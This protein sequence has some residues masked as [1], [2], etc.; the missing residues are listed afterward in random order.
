MKN[1]G[2]DRWKKIEKLMDEALEMELSER[3]AYVRKKGGDDEA[4]IADVLKMLTASQAAGTFLESKSKTH[5]QG[6]LAR[7]AAVVAEGDSETD[8]IKTVGPYRLIRQLGRGG[9]GQVFLAVRDDEA[10]KRY[11]A[12][13]II[14]RGMDTQDIL[15]RFRVERQILA[16]LTHP[17]IAHLLDGGAT[18]EGLSYFVMEYVDGVPINRYCNEN[19]LSLE[20]RLKLF[21][22]VAAA[23]HYA[24]Q[25]LIVHRD[26]KPANILVTT[27]GDVKLLD[28]GIAKFLNP[29]LVGYTLPMT[30]TEMR[31]MTPE[32]AS[33]EQIRG[34][35]VTTASD[36]YQLGI[37][38]YELLTGHCPFSFQTV[39]RG[40]IEKIILEKAPEKPSTMI[41]RVEELPRAI[42]NP[43]LISVQ[44]RTPLERLRKQLTGDLDHIVLMALRKEIDRRYQSADQLL[45]DIQNYRAGRPVTAQADTWRY[46]TS[47]FVQRN[48]M[49][50]GAT[51]LV[52]LLLII[53]T[54]LSVQFA[55]VTAEQRDQIALQAQ[56]AEQVKD[57]LIGIFEQAN[58]EFSTGEGLNARQ[59]V[60]LGAK[61][62]LPKLAD[63]PAI[64]SEIMYTIALIYSQL[65]L[66]EE[67][68]PLV[69]R[70]LE[71]ER[72]LSEDGVS[73][74]LARSLYGMGYLEDE[75]GEGTLAV[76]Y[77]SKSL[78]IRR[79]LFGESNLK[80][81][82]SL[83]E[84][85]VAM[86][87]HTNADSDTLLTLFEQALNIRLALLEDGDKDIAQTL[88]NIASVH[89]DMGNDDLAE[90]T[91]RQALAMIEDHLGVKHPFYAST[92]YNL[93]TLLKD[94][95]PYEAERLFRMALGIRINLYGTEHDA[96][97]NTLNWLGRV[98]QAQGLLSEAEGFFLESKD[99]HE[100]IFG[101]NV[102]V[103][104]R[105]WD[106]LGG[107]YEVSGRT[108][109]ALRAY[110]QA[111]SIARIAGPSYHP[112]TFTMHQNLAR[113]Q[114]SSGNYRAAS[115]NLK[116]VIDDFLEDWTD[117]DPDIAEARLSL[118]ECLVELR[119]RD[120]AIS[121]LDKALG[122]FEADAE[123]YTAAIAR[124]QKLKTR[125]GGARL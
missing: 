75:L 9:M 50:V 25:N 77:L 71:I 96:V 21:V 41:S 98:K 8:E 2:P 125:A 84:L 66:W 46:R 44:R 114:M 28:F 5:L 59:L 45:Q 104:A 37:L 122:F 63:Q 58:P 80:T 53:T 87:N 20:N 42:V 103:V 112:A 85:A 97:A 115:A 100:R 107:F 1:V 94:K 19:R 123:Y 26:L 38:L 31:L 48:K 17:N 18:D 62:V 34:N 69:E 92:L 22:K 93:G 78:Q 49:G 90:S 14:R 88:V 81:A 56:K 11:V 89:T 120:E 30:R 47:K 117:N 51:A 29:D 4:L 91:Y 55:I 43:E 110:S 23:V 86:Y 35:T 82:E 67:A 105:D 6:E 68:K 72:E 24:H 108:E 73:D 57:F 111:V 76:A 27:D 70:S 99:I 16:S 61:T 83:N 32:Y 116:Y 64:Q 113:V 7:M 102:Y 121:V 106:K 3:E 52:A 109:E 15:I 119:S 101:P 79:T 118:G 12:I 60:D 65:G 10:F 54:F 13:K 40:E 95:N 33:P 39:A 74:G 36:V 124:A